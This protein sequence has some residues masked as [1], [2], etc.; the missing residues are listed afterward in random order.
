MVLWKLAPTMTVSMRSQISGGG[1]ANE[2]RKGKDGD[3][4]GLGIEL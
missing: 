2:E 1:Q 4:L 3:S